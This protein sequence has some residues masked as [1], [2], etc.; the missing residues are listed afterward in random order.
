M[1]VSIFGESDV[2]AAAQRARSLTQ[3]LDFSEADRVRIET[4]ILELGRNVVLYAGQ[5]EILVQV[6]KRRGRVGVQVR[7]I[8]RG[9]GIADVALALQDGYLTS[10][11]LGTGLGSVRRLVDEFTIES[12]VGRGTRVTAV[13]W[14]T[15]S[16]AEAHDQVA[17]GAAKWTAY[18]N[19]GYANTTRR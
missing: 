16:V 2:Y 6:M 15:G 13:K 12:A 3:G 9:P 1:V 14:V 18:W 11:G 5:G 10:G 4:V 19:Y 7:A 8:D 17:Q